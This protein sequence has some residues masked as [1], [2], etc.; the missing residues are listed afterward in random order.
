MHQNIIRQWNFMGMPYVHLSWVHKCNLV[1]SV[2]FEATSPIKGVG[3]VY[4]DEI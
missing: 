3:F 4:F 2:Y 1:M